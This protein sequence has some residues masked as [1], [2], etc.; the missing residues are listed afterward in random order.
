MNLKK[1]YAALLGSVD[2]ELELY[3]FLFAVDMTV[4]ALLSA[5]P[6]SY[7]LC[8]GE[9]RAPETA[10]DALD[11]AAP[12]RIPFIAY[13]CAYLQKDDAKMKEALALADR[14]YLQL[15]RERAKGKRLKGEKW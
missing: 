4:G 2:R 6:K 8:G 12:F 14:A 9:Y 13:L 10:D 11:I 15:W 7:V 3:R 1:L 5:A